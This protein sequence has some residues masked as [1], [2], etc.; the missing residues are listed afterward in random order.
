VS[1]KLSKAATDAKAHLVMQCQD[2]GL[3]LPRIL[4]GLS[5]REM[6][7][8][9]YEQ[10]KPANKFAGQLLLIRATKGDGSAGDMPYQDVYENTLLGWEA[11]CGGQVLVRDVP[12]GHSTMLND[13]NVGA[14]AAAIEST[15]EQSQPDHV[16]TVSYP[17]SVR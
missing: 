9:A 1:S 5:V 6:L 11:F 4:R 17:A 13:E 14:I 7:V 16:Y 10:Y 12:G 3:K 8:F 15:I 2:R